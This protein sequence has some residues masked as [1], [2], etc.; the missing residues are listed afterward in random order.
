MPA[1]RAEYECVQFNLVT[2]KRQISNKLVHGNRQTCHKLQTVVTAV[3]LRH[4]LKGG[5]TIAFS[6]LPQAVCSVVWSSV[7]FRMLSTVEAFDMP[8]AFAWQ[9][10]KRN[11]PRTHAFQ[12]PSHDLL[13]CRL[14]EIRRR[15]TSYLVAW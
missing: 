11:K 14:T 5:E 4:L 7:V 13:Q 10:S 3:H 12:L 9:S 15:Q 1:R 8:A 2:E 6:H